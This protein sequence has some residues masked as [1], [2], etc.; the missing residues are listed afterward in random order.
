MADQN[1]PSGDIGNLSN[2]A[3]WSSPTYIGGS[4]NNLPTSASSNAGDPIATHENYRKASL[5]DTY[6]VLGSASQLLINQS[7][8]Q[9]NALG[10]RNNTAPSFGSVIYIGFGQD[11][12]LLSWLQLASGEQVFFDTVVPQDDIYAASNG[13]GLLAYV[14]STTAG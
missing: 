11:A 7:V 8:V 2:L 12:S 13:V 3:P 4:P 1:T 10:F 5:V 14:Y 6:V 9:R